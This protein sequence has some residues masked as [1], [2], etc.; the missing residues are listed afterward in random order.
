[1]LVRLKKK[2]ILSG[3]FNVAFLG[4][5]VDAYGMIVALKCLHLVTFYLAIKIEFNIFF[6]L[7]AWHND[8]FEHLE[9]GFF[10]LLF[11]RV[12]SQQNI[13]TNIFVIK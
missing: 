3:K 8:I 6:Y 4:L 13:C 1:M 12:F 11:F 7:S 10:A 5:L 9:I 2:V